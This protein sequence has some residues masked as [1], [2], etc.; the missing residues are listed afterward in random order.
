MVL[1]SPHVC[2]KQLVTFN[3]FPPADASWFRACSEGLYH[4]G[5]LG[6]IFYVNSLGVKNR[7]I[8]RQTREDFINDGAWAETKFQYHQMVC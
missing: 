1:V 7:P 8:V 5:Y 6:P 3:P 4:M 2:F